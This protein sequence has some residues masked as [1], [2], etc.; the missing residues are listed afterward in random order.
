MTGW[1]R[2]ADHAYHERADIVASNGVAE[3]APLYRHI[4]NHFRGRL[5]GAKSFSDAWTSIE[6]VQPDSRFLHYFGRNLNESLQ[7]G[8]A[9]GRSQILNKNAQLEDDLHE[10]RAIIDGEFYV[11]DDKI[12]KLSYNVIPQDVLDYIEYKAFWISGVEHDEL[13]ASIKNNLINAI[14]N[15]VK[16]DDWRKQVDK[17]FEQYDVEKPPTYNAETIFRTNVLSTYSAAKLA[18]VAEIPDRFPAWQYSAIMDART[19]PDH[20]ALDGQVF[21]IDDR[22][23]YPPWDYNCR[24]SAVLLHV[25]EVPSDVQLKP[26]PISTPRSID[27]EGRD[28]ANW[29]EQK[30]AAMTPQTK[31]AVE[32]MLRRE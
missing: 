18:Q 28:F 29:L 10:A 24:C 21:S 9:L 26:A 22:D 4:M 11:C 27:V 25:S 23:Y 20:A 16:F 17:L 15:G 2:R 7:T 8:D 6:N 13:L 30:K 5:A 14:R 31:A 12:V 1:N 3:S 32:K 19:R